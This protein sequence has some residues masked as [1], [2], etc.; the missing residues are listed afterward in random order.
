MSLTAIFF[1]PG[2]VCRYSKGIGSAYNRLPVMLNRLSLPGLTPQVGFTRL[3]AF[4]INADLGQARGPLQ[5]I[6]F[7]KRWM[8]GCRRQVYAVCKLDCVPAHDGG[9]Q[10]FNSGGPRCSPSESN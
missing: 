5:S 9:E 1:R 4:I 7:A 8:R 3:E 6:L 10:R 2:F